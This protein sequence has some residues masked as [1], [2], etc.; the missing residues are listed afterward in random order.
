MQEM[1]EMDRLVES[2]LVS[3]VLVE[4]LGFLELATSRTSVDLSVGSIQVQL[5]HL[6]QQV[7]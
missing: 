2:V 6:S 7:T 4:L 5:I 1:E 3:E